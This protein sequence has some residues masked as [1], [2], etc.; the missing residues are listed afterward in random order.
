[1]KR[2]RTGGGGGEKGGE[3]SFVI[4]RFASF[5]LQPALHSALCTL[6]SALLCANLAPPAYVRSYHSHRSHHS[7][8]T[9]RSRT[10]FTCPPLAAFCHPSG[11]L[12]RCPGRCVSGEYP[13]QRRDPIPRR[14]G[15]PVGAEQHVQEPH[16]TPPPYV[17][18]VAVYVCR[19]EC[20]ERVDRGY[21]V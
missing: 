8:H 10:P 11:R 5:V 21:R 19:V 16:R 20:V 14:A 15:Q 7:Y 9:H 13:S 3:L 17:T 12:L 2:G 4:D 1:M 6:H 18:V